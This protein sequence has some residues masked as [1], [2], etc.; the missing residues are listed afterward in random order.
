MRVVIDTNVWL[1]II[2]DY[3]KYA[4]VYDLIKN[5]KIALILTNDIFLEYEE[6]MNVRYPTTSV[7]EELQRLFKL[8]KTE[9]HTPKYFWNLIT[10][11]PDDNK[12]VDCAIT[13]NADFIITNDKHFDVLKTIDF[14]IVNTLTLQEFLLN[15]HN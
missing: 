5:D 4:V 14:P 15:F 7:D 9:L 10:V 12:F 1:V 3:S 13:A 11:D 2:P 8:P 6:L